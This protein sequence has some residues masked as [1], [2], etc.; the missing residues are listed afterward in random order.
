MALVLFSIGPSLNA[1]AQVV[2]LKYKPAS[3][4][5]PLKGLVPYWGE[6]G[7][8]PCSMEF[9]Y[10]PISDL[11]TGPAEFDFSSVERKLEAA[12]GRG[13][14]MVIRTY[15]EY[16]GQKSALPGFLKEKGV[17]IIEYRH[18]GKLNLTPDYHDPKL[19]KAMETFVAAFGKKFDG[20]PRIGCITM[21]VLGHWGEW[22]TYP[23]ANLFATKQDQLRIQDAFVRAFKK[24]KVLMRYPAGADDWSHAPNDHQPFGYHDD[25]FAWATLDTGKPDDDWFFEPALKNAGDHAINKWKTQPIGGEIRPEIWG[26]VFDTPSC[27][28]SGQEF[29]TAVERL[30][31]SWL[32]DS[33]MFPRERSSLSKARVT[34]AIR[35]VRKMG[36]EFHISTVE[37]AQVDERSIITIDIENRGVAP[38]YYP[39]PVEMVMFD[40]RGKEL[41]TLATGWK[42]P[43][44][45]PGLSEK[46]SVT[47]SHPNGVSSFGLRVPNPMKGGKPIRFAN[48]TQQDDGLL[49]LQP[50]Q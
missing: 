26:C 29:E 44:L 38:F 43:D 48:E 11:M 28:P 14:Q 30:H 8:F 23:K 31:V 24:T 1:C 27:A 42:L 6:A 46:W 36:Y 9:W 18:D 16:P 41:S 45:L 19:I 34:E 20:D 15:L 37:I 22:H 32:L 4:D 49:L 47:V 39:W 40:S 10:F 35:Q 12:R 3:V 25:S 5:N 33:G 17:K 7:A 21:G 50:S 2:A 13:N